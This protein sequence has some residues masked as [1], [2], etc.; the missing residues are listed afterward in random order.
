MA[1]A[2]AALS[3]T[4]NVERF[5]YITSYPSRFTVAGLPSDLVELATWATPGPLQLFLR[6]AQ[7]V[8]NPDPSTLPLDTFIAREEKIAWERLLENVHP[9]GTAKGCVVASPNRELPD[10]W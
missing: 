7:G 1:A 6:S 5:E 8:I 2:L 10:Y 9:P 3:V 4:S